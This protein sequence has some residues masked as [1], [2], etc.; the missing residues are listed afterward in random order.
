MG[1]KLV[2]DGAVL[3]YTTAGAVTKDT[4]IKIGDTF[5][6][7]LATAAGSGEVIPVALEGVFTLSKIAAASTALV[8]GGL[9]YARATGSVFKVLAVATGNAMGTAFA[10]AATGA[11]TGVVKLHGFATN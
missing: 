8:A 3:N 10:A 2:Q 1:T 7:P 6:V 9:V 4:L 5:G 11:T